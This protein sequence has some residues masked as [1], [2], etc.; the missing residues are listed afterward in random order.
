MGVNKTMLSK[1]INKI[2]KTE[3]PAGSYIET[4]TATQLVSLSRT[5][6]KRAINMIAEIM[7][8]T[9]MPP[10]VRVKAAEILLD[11]GYGKAAQAMVVSNSDG[12]PLIG[13]QALSIA[14]RI[15]ALKRA[16]ET[17]DDTIDLE[18]N[19]AIPVQEEQD[20]TDIL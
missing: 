4:V 13:A 7:E 14:E 17:K 16:K 18:A 12:S 9:G 11:R 19:D 2:A 10:A 8:D 1:R 15:A 20:N 5:F 6:S 3:I